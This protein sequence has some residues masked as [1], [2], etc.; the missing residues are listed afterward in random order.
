[1]KSK[2]IKSPKKV[3]E[4][5]INKD[6]VQVGLGKPRTTASKKRAVIFA[7]SL[8]RKWVKITQSRNSSPSQA[9]GN[10][11]AAT[12]SIMDR[13]S[14]SK[15]PSLGSTIIPDQDTVVASNANQ[16][17]TLPSL[18]EAQLTEM[19]HAGNNQHDNHVSGKIFCIRHFTPM[20]L[21]HW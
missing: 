6:P 13:F 2:K 21:K 16:P 8:L 7:A 10:Q 3:K 15:L 9:G 20:L 1:M 18:I 4:A 12:T 14:S 19:I 17:S 5:H 11:A